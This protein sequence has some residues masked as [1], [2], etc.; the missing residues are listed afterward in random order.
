[1][2]W[3]HADS[4][5]GGDGGQLFE[6]HR[7]VMVRNHGQSSSNMLF[8]PGKQAKGWKMTGGSFV[9][10]PHSAS[11]AFPKDFTVEAWVNSSF[12]G[13]IVA[14]ITPGG[15]DGFLLDV[16]E[17]KLRFLVGWPGVA[18]PANFPF[19]ELVHVV[20]VF[21]GGVSMRLYINGQKKAER[22]QGILSSFPAGSTPMRFGINLSGDEAS[23][24][25][26]IIDEVRIYKKAL[27]DAQVK[28][29]YDGK[30]CAIVDPIRWDFI[31]APPSNPGCSGQ[32]AEVAPHYTD[33]ASGFFSHTA[34]GCDAGGYPFSTAVP[35]PD[36]AFPYAKVTLTEPLE[37]AHVSLYGSSN[38]FFPF[39]AGV[40]L[41]AV[42]ASSPLGANGFTSIGTY[43]NPPHP[44]FVNPGLFQAGTL[45]P[46]TYYLRFR[47]LV[48]PNPTTSQMRFLEHSIVGV[49]AP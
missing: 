31:G 24:F 14:K 10:V 38:P 15:Q 22:T 29:A 37:Q 13:T 12:N 34:T 47:P 45:A 49:R 43:V 46:G 30:A 36:G 41:S 19:D 3:W 8:G 48:V 21:E 20:A 17:N 39:D 4:T 33:A 5:P 25:K 35:T 27:T 11:L 26:G 16:H 6:L 9:E 23:K 1:M 18:D 7:D 40:E 2:S 44:V 32:L 42:G 28:V